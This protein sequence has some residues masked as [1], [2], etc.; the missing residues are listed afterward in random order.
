[1]EGLGRGCVYYHGTDAVQCPNTLLMHTL[2]ALHMEP[3]LQDLAC[4]KGCCGSKAIAWVAGASGVRVFRRHL[5]RNFGLPARQT[6]FS[7][8]KQKTS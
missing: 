6:H 8:K 5:T 3:P 1:M 7:Y 4:S 2:E